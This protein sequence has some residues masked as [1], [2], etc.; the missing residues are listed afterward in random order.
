MTTL[1][2]DPRISVAPK[3][4]LGSIQ[5]THDQV[6]VL[7]VLVVYTVV[8]FAIWNIPGA[9]S[10]INPLKLLTIGFHEMCHIIMAIFTGGTILRVTIDPNLGGCTLVEGG[11]P[12]VILAAGYI[13]STIFGGVL[14]LGGW[15]TLVAK[16]ESFVV[17]IGLIVP[18]VLVRDKMTILLTFVYEGLLIGF[19]FIDHASALRWYVLFVGVMN[20]FYVIWDIADDRFFH[21][22]NDS[23]CAQFSI[24][25]PKI[26]A[27]AWAA[28][29]I[30]FEIGAMIG[31]T[32]VGIACFKRTNDTMAREA[33]HWL[34][35]REILE[36][37]GNLTGLFS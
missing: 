20:V 4:K 32:L 19:W 29:W 3:E 37:V 16:I 2:S 17:G 34:P 28:I 18:L 31:F 26:S 8:I 13:G 9:R 11:Y 10:L 6:V 33:A 27:H 30:L 15:D 24:L 5:P 23:D 35:T 25:F 22:A 36:K 21:K 12:P 14:M 7:Y 1:A